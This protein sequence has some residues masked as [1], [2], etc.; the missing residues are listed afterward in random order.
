MH[1]YIFSAA[2]TYVTN[3]PNGLDVKNFGL[4][5]ILRVGTQNNLVPYISPTTDYTYVNS[6][7]VHVGVQDFNGQ[8][9]GSIIGTDVT[10]SYAVLN[11]T[12]YTGSFEVDNFTGSVVSGSGICF[13]GTASGMDTRQEVSRQYISQSYIDRAFF[14]LT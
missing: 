12:T 1:H 9:T 5:E 4:T 14:N 3:R 8:F 2:D 13:Y 6:T 7:F 11:G 10:S